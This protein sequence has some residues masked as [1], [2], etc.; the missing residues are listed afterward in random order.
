MRGAVAP[1]Y[2]TYFLGR[3]DLVSTFI[4]AGMLASLVGA[5]STNVLSKYFC[6]VRL[7]R[8][9]LVGVVVFHAVIY[10]LTP[11]ALIS[12]FIISMLAQFSQM[13]VVPLMFSMVADT[14][15]FGALK[16]GRKIMAMSFSAHLLSIKLGLAVGGALVGWLLSYFGYVANTEQ[17]SFALTGIVFIFSIAGAICGLLVAVVMAKYSLTNEEM[18]SVNDK[19]AAQK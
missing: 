9:G 3:E 15:D 1:Y 14:A 17:T 13:I 6:K 4:T 10:F 2:V 16:T 7:F 19:L 11:D 8:W 18:I 12:I 5:L